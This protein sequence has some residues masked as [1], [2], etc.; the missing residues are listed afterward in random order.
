MPPNPPR[1]S[2]ACAYGA[3]IKPS[4]FE[5]APPIENMLRGP[6][7]LFLMFVNRGVDLG[8]DKPNTNYFFTGLKT[9]Q[10]K[11]F[12]IIMYRRLNH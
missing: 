2:K 11:L 3:L 6:C 12:I 10:S 1:N 9:A 7:G 8:V 5:L 4:V